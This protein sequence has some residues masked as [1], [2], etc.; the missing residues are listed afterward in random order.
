M[1][2][3]DN[4]PLDIKHRERRIEDLNS[5][6]DDLYD[7]IDDL[8]VRINDVTVRMASV[9]L[10]K[11]SNEKVIAAIELFDKL[12]DVMNDE[13]KKQAITGIV[14]EIHVNEVPSANNNYI[15]EVV[16]IFDLSNSES[17]EYTVSGEELNQLPDLSY[18]Y[19]ENT[20]LEIET[21]KEYKRSTKKYYVPKHKLTYKMI[22]D[23]VLEHYGLK[24]HSTYIAEIKRKLGIDMQADRHNKKFKYECP[25]EKAEA[26][27][28]ALKYYKVI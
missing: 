14:K 7:T 6:L 18:D 5:R 15:K 8:E 1:N 27:E 25:K 17:F 11:L 22:Q 16:L 2:E 4:M 28:E 3:L 26:I 24:V 19:V 12:Y 21:N 10:G 13:E 20:Y 23:Y 9:E